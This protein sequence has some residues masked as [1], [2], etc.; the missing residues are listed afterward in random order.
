MMSVLT[1]PI[2]SCSKNSSRITGSLKKRHAIK[3]K[4]IDFFLFTEDIIISK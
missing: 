2:Q 3:M 4:E 1:A